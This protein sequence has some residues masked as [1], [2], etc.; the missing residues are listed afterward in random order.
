ML[1]RLADSLAPASSVLHA[2]AL[3]GEMKLTPGSTPEER[4][5][6]WIKIIN[7]ARAYPA[8]VT[9]YCDDHD[10]SKNN[11]YQWFKRLRKQHP[12]WKHDLPHNPAKASKKRKKRQPKKEP[13]ETEVVEKKPKRRKFTAA[14]KARI[15]KEADSALPGQLGAL[16]R[17][18]G[19]YSSHLQKW[20]AE[21]DVAALQPKKRGP[22]ANPLTAENKQLKKQ[23]EK[24]AKRLR[25][26]EKIIE[27]Q[28]KMSEILGVT[29]E[30]IDED[31]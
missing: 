28:K 25:Q 16:L 14:E 21:R 15:L 18:E 22:Q 27:L 23:N 24:L 26:A 2:I 12:E 8:G 9:A 19:I 17:R 11:Y 3:E 6:Y 4:E 29:L 30:T 31:D 13:R 20:R 10:I 5:A 1:M 7:E